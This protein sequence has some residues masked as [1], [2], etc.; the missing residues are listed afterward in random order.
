MTKLQLTCDVQAKQIEHL[1]E[2]VEKTESRWLE[3]NLM[4]CGFAERGKNENCED[5]VIQIV[6]K[7][8]IKA[9]SRT[10]QYVYRLG[11]FTKSRPRPII[12]RFQHMKDRNQTWINRKQLHNEAQYIRPMYPPTTYRTRRVLQAVHSFTES[13]PRFKGKTR[14]LYSHK[15]QVDKDSYQIEDLHTLPEDLQKAVGTI[16]QGNITAFFG[17]NC[18]FSNFYPSPFNINDRRFSS[19]EQFNYYSA[20]EEVTVPGAKVKRHLMP[21]ILDY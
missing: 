15:M 18:P 14:L 7:L 6:Q 12:A 11:R 5:L 9:D 10:F 4:F 2:R 1:Q 20:L 17:I 19:N 16:S 21:C 8:G 13:V 3:N